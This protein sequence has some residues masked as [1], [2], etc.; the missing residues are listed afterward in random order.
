[1]ADADAVV[2]HANNVNVARQLRDRFPHPYSRANAQAFLKMSASDT[3]N[4]AIEVG[5]EAVGR[6]ATSS[7]QTSNVFPPRLDTGSARRTGA[8][9]SPPRRSS[10]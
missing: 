8:V 3:T 1:M 2:R 9:A 6:S 4:L 5:G 7:A 10:S